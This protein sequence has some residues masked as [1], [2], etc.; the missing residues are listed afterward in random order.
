M[1]IAIVVG[2][3]VASNNHARDSSFE[4]PLHIT[5][6][7]EELADGLLTPSVVAVCHAVTISPIALEVDGINKKEFVRVWN[8]E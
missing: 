6:M 5:D 3:E 8:F 1:Q 7:G 2:I 4:Q